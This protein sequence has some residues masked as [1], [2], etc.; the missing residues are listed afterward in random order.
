MK[1]NEIVEITIEDIGVNGEGIGKVDGYALFVKDAVIGDRIEAKITKAKKNYAYARMMKILEPSLN[2]VAPK[3]PVARQCGGCQ[4]QELSYE[5]QLEFKEKKV[6]GNLERIGG[7]SP[8]LIEEVMEP[9]CGMENPFYYR[10]KAQFPFGTDK[11]GNII[12][13]FY[14]GRTHQIIPNTKCALGV[15]QNKQILEMIV[16]F[17]NLYHVTAYNEETGEGL[18]RHALIRYGFKTGEIM[19][20]L[21]INGDKIPHS[22]KLV[23]KL[24]EIPGMTSITLN[25]NKERS[26]VILGREINVLWGQEYITDYIGNVKYQISPLSFYQ[27]NPVQT[28]KL[29]GLALE[30]AD[31][32]G[33]ETVWDLYCGIGTISLFLAQKA[34]QVYGVEIIPQAI[35]DAKN[36]AKI[37]GIENAEFFVGKAEEILPAYYVDYE[38]EYGEKAH[39]DVIVVDPPRKGCEESLLRTMVDME[40][41]RIVYVSCDSATLARDLKILCE[42]GYEIK[43]VRA[44]DQFPMTV[45]VETVC[46]LSR[47]KSVKRYVHVDVTPEELGMRG[48][49]K[50]VKHPTYPQIREYVKEKHGLTVSS[51]NIASV[52]DECGMEKQFSYKEAGMA[53]KKRPN[54]PKKKRDAIVEAFVHF[55]MLSQS[56]AEALDA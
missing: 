53:A 9:I 17:M 19:V 16:E 3:C 40:P 14:A 23:D 22:E 2:R 37:N 36:N 18:L 8:E 43:K 26:N 13:G 51:A 50:N 12:T 38:K 28:E 42:N 39:A 33:E 41:E 11:E 25:V 47:E 45:H 10:N 31:L 7:F 5:K 21:V 20:C 48:K 55:G 32:K 52:K 46:L 44:V 30:Y 1:K 29:Y 4:I 54:C 49:S 27:V 6:R 56:D 15:K 34:K 35:E 24:A